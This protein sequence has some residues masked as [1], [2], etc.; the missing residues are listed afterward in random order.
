MTNVDP[1]PQTTS[2]QR[3]AHSP[4]EEGSDPRSWAEDGYPPEH[5]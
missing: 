5:V 3:Q 2:G 4:C 1:A